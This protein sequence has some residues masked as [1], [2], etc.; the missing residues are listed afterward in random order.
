MKLNSGAFLSPMLHLILRRV[1][2]HF[3]HTFIWQTWGR[4]RRRTGKWERD[5]VGESRSIRR[6]LQTVWSRHCLSGSHMQDCICCCI[7][8]CSFYGCLYVHCVYTTACLS[9]ADGKC[10]VHLT[11][12]SKVLCLLSVSSP[13]SIVPLEFT[14]VATRLKLVWLGDTKHSVTHGPN[15]YDYVAGILC[16]LGVF[17]ADIK[18]TA[19]VL[20][21]VPK[22]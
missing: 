8:T 22:K 2:C 12:H 18:L 9:A 14:Y 3:C 21:C 16:A 7:N 15:Y 19:G 11:L 6:A 10:Q 13:V 4:L 1:L 5:W 20:Q 17:G